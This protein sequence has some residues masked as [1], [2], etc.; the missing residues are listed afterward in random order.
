MPNLYA[1]LE[2]IA[3]ILL[4]LC[5]TR[6]LCPQQAVLSDCTVHKIVVQCVKNLL[7]FPKSVIVSV[8]MVRRV[9]IVFKMKESKNVE[10]A[11][12]FHYV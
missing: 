12:T 2:Y 11:I 6:S 10:E 8:I 4:F 9:V 7:Y 5:T 1:S 3:E